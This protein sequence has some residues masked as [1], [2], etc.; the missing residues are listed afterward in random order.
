MLAP[1]TTSS[2]AGPRS[3]GESLASAASSAHCAR[4]APST[5]RSGSA[6]APPA[7]TGR[8]VRHPVAVREQASRGSA[9]RLRL[10]PRPGPGPPSA[11]AVAAGAALAPGGDRE[12]RIGPV[13]PGRSADD[14]R[15]ALQREAQRRSVLSPQFAAFGQTAHAAPR[16][17]SMFRKRRPQCFAD[18]V[19]AATFPGR[20]SR[21]LLNLV[22]I[23]AGPP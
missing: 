1:G 4:V 14:L 13:A 20:S 11:G 10:F 23:V 12:R 7:P 21:V 3:G 9:L 16:R 8:L 15:R 2:A 18:R 19:G 5:S 22:A 6:R 17:S